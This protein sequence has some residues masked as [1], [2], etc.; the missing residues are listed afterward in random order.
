MRDWM[1]DW[2]ASHSWR[3][4]TV[5]TW[6][7]RWSAWAGGALLPDRTTAIR[8]RLIVARDLIIDIAPILAWRRTDPDAAV[9]PYYQT[10]LL[11]LAGK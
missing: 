1:H 10:L 2:P 4:A 5:E 8:R 9:G 11:I 6:T 7:P 3:F